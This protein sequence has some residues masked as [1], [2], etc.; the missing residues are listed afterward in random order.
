MRFICFFIF[1]RFLRLPL[2]LSPEL[3]LW[4]N[5]RHGQ[6]YTVLPNEN[7]VRRPILNPRG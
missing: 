4:R 5:R 6:H 7:Q 3:E 1:D 2:T